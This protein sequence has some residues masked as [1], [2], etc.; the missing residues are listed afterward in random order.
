MNKM[1]TLSLELS[2][3]D[4]IPDPLERQ[5][6]VIQTH[7]TRGLLAAEIQESECANPDNDL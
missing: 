6:L 2:H 3:L 1:Q 5:G 7:V 4:V